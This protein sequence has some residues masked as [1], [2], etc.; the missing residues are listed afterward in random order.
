MKTKYLIYACIAFLTA[1]L[2]SFYSCNKETSNL[3]KTTATSEEL[4]TLSMT[5][6]SS[7]IGY[8]DS[9]GQFIAITE[10]QLESFFQQ[11]DFIS[12][13]GTMNEYG[14]IQGYDST[15]STNLYS[16]IA[17]A[18]D[19]E[20]SVKMRFDL[21]DAGNNQFALFAGGCSCK[22]TKCGPWQCNVSEFGPCDCSP[23]T[24]DDGVCEK[25][26]SRFTRAQI[27][28]FF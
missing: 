24:T 15:T 6:P 12:T 14:V 3:A 26:S 27:S 17:T 28:S 1:G 25:T 10:Q 16:V 21:E 7:V 18:T 22:S 19:G 11:I 2:I 4:H 5:I 8:I 9:S 13:N 20:Y 23:C